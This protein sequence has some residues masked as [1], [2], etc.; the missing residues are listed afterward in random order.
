MFLN[1]QFAWH[2]GFGWWHGKLARVIQ[3]LAAVW[4]MTFAEARTKLARELASIELVPY[5][6]EG[7][8][9]AGG[10]AKKLPSAQLA[11][12]FVRDVVLRKVRAGNAIVIVARKARVWGLLNEPGVI[13]YDGGEARRAHLGPKSR[14]GQAILAHLTSYGIAADRPGT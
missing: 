4:S 7:F 12:Q 9:N 11:A 14:G 13:I 2:G 8:S 3:Q 5:H 6:S 10:L 1:P